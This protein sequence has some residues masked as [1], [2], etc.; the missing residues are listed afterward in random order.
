MALWTSNTKV[1]ESRGFAAVLY[2]L[3]S[4]VHY[5]YFG[6]RI[7][8]DWLMKVQNNVS[9]KEVEGCSTATKYI[10]F[11]TLSGK[12]NLIEYLTHLAFNVT[13]WHEMVGTLTQY[14]TP[15]NGFGFSLRPGKAV[16]DVQSFVQVQSSS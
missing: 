6:A 5:L 16:L 10:E 13:A 12:D 1:K 7:W 14:V 4:L 11:F 8:C 15:P 9:E 3:Y 2:P